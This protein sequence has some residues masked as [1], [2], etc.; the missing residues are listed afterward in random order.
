MSKEPNSSGRVT[1]D[2]PEIFDSRV[3]PPPPGMEVQY[4]TIGGALVRGVINKDNIHM[5]MGWMPFPKM[6][7]WLKKRIEEQ[8]EQFR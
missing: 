5:C 8:Y 3:D 1:S 4:F 6:P 2:S 7:A